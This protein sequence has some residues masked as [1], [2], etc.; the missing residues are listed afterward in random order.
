MA[1]NAAHSDWARHRLAELPERAAVAV[2]G[3]TYKPGTSTLRRSSAVAL[4]EWLVDRGFAVS[5]FDPEADVPEGALPGVGLA[6]SAAEALG[7]A[8]A[9]VIATP[10]PEFRDLTPDDLVAAMADPIV[11][12]EGWSLAALAEDDR[13]TYIAPGRAMS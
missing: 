12:D 9:A 11:I 6:G 7:G 10:W 1:S 13:I 5:A 8:A 3:L 2:L 4:C